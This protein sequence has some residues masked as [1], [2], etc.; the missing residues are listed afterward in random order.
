MS[1][2]NINKLAKYI[3]HH[4]NNHH[5][6]GLDSPIRQRG[7]RVAERN[8]VAHVGDHSSGRRRLIQLD[9]DPKPR[10]PRRRS[11]LSRRCALGSFRPHRGRLG[12]SGR[13]RP[14]RIAEAYP[15]NEV[16]TDRAPREDCRQ[17]CARPIPRTEETT[18]ASPE[19]GSKRSPVPSNR[20]DDTRPTRRS[21]PAHA[22][23]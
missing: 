5:H 19:R 10:N 22:V 13:R 15:P 17:R 6:S 7:C 11:P 12:E 20:G 8:A 9:C 3:I 16:R 21:R 4:V 2:S 23:S 18:S 1:N 14:A